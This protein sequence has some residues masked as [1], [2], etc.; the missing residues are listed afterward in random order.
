M[1][2]LVLA[3]ILTLPPVAAAAQAP[4]SP[5]E[6]VAM[7]TLLRVCLDHASGQPV[8]AL[9]QRAQSGGFQRRPDQGGVLG[10]SL[11]W[12]GAG[13]SEVRL[14]LRRPEGVTPALCR[15][16]VDHGDVDAVRLADS[17]VAWAEATSPAFAP[18]SAPRDDFANPFGPKPALHRVFRRP[19]SRLTV[20]RF[21]RPA[22]DGFDSLFA[23]QAVIISLERL[24]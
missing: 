15:I 8:E 13:R 10:E 19:G 21:D 23:N 5:A 22:G 9:L 7:T 6:S 2:H 14:S 1:R 17:V 4:E 11:T 18:D 12:R 24:R 3:A 20:E 16:E